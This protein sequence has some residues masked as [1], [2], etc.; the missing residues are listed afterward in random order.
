MVWSVLPLLSLALWR[1]AAGQETGRPVTVRVDCREGIGLVPDFWRGVSDTEGA[2]PDAAEWRTVCLSPEPVEKAWAGRL[3]GAGYRWS[4][5]EAA[6]RAL[7]ASG[8]DVVLPLPAPED[9]LAV[10]IWSD[11][12]HDTVQRTAG[13]VSRFEIRAGKGDVARY[14]ENYE[15]AV[16]A[17]Y[18]ANPEARVGGPGVMGRG[19]HVEALVRHCRKRSVPL[20]F[21]SW[22][23]R[24][25]GPAALA[26]SI[27]AARGY[28]DRYA[29]QERPQ[30][31]VTRWRAEG[32]GDAA[33]A[34]NTLSSLSRV[35]GTE[36]EA[37]CLELPGNR[38]GIAALG[39][40]SR[41]GRLRLVAS[42]EP[43]GCG[44]E[45]V[46]S[47]DDAIGVLLWG[48]DPAQ[49]IRV[50]LVL[51][52]LPWGSGIRFERHDLAP[53]GSEDAP[54]AVETVPMQDPVEVSFPLV[55]GRITSVRATAV[56]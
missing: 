31:L 9:G 56:D 15:L 6:L 26:A 41:M 27:T 36:L 19:T 16:W 5:L 20:H 21:L 25:V 4:A 7:D 55:P 46:A 48:G 32:D 12:V 11:L 50:R 22:Q 43:E 33:V 39:A 47:L 44:V 42:V 45:V 2:L 10:E 17:A 23:V 24:A 37:I 3:A 1:S 30:L 40:L 35:L 29:F 54:A 13:R 49:P 18:R 28:L 38:A 52:G 14:L 53:G 8:V 34:G 51:N